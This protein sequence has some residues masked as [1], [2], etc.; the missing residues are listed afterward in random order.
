MLTFFFL[1]K[2][3]TFPY[4]SHDAH[5][6]KI[7]DFSWDR[8]GQYNLTTST[9]WVRLPA[10]T[11]WRVTWSKACWLKIYITRGGMTLNHSEVCKYN[12]SNFRIVDWLIL[13]HFSRMAAQAVSQLVS[14]ENDSNNSF[15]VISVLYCIMTIKLKLS[16]TYN[17]QYW[18]LNNTGL[19][20][21]SY[22]FVQALY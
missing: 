12:D 19:C 21:A 15:H 13:L 7:G 1:S 8:V 2:N 3:H 20:W 17:P 4:N 22:L 9:R 6:H 14:L 5:L 18:N 10:Q 11:D 16:K